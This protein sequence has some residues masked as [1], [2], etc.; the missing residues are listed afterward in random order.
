M[1]FLSLTHLLLPTLCLG[2]ALINTRQTEPCAPVS[3]AITNYR[4]T[5]GP[6]GARITFD[7][8][9]TFSDPSII[10]DS[11]SAGAVCDANSPSG[12]IPTSNACS[13]GRQ[14]LGFD[15][16]APQQNHDFQIFH[17]W[18]CNG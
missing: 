3:Y 10:E 4:Y 17:D 8:Q 15:L 14:N 11:A 7:F 1:Y 5:S 18:R 13:T 12:T 2:A 16:R 6:A 9:S